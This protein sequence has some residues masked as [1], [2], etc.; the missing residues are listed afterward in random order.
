MQKVLVR[1][2]KLRK[3]SCAQSL[4]YDFH[5]QAVRPASIARLFRVGL[6]LGPGRRP[7]VGPPLRL[8]QGHHQPALQLSHPHAR[9][10]AAQPLEVYRVE[11]VLSAGERM[12]W[13]IGTTRERHENGSTCV[14]SARSVPPRRR[15]RGGRIVGLGTWNLV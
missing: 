10:V 11:P 14:C 3:R 1:H 7:A 8:Y 12:G 4:L 13:Y 5:R 2:K 9:H 6:Q 15:T